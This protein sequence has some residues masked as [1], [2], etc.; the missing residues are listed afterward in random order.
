MPIRDVH[1]RIELQTL[2]LS[3]QRTGPT[4]VSCPLSAPRSRPY[5][6]RIHT[7]R[8]DHLPVLLVRMGSQCPGLEGSDQR[9]TQIALEEYIL[10]IRDEM[11]YHQAPIMEKLL[12]ENIVTAW[13]RVQHCESQLAWRMTGSNSAATLEFWE[14]RLSTCQRRYLAACETLAKIRKMRLPNIQLNIGDKQINATGDLKPGTTEI[15]NV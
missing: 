1:E 3:G 15:I 11:G 9:V 12:I 13:L 2:P 4:R 6:E 10:S 7:Q 5:R 14:R 8:A